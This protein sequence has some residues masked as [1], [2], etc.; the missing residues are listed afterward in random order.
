MQGRDAPDSD[1]SLSLSTRKAGPRDAVAT[2]A[3]IV[4]RIFG[5]CL[6]V[7]MP[8]LVMHNLYLPL[9]D[10]KQPLAEREKPACSVQLDLYTAGFV[11]GNG[12]GLH[13]ARQD[14]V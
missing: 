7:T 5:P 8:I 14:R 2:F 6:S 13:T 10:F 11:V 3:L 9:A 4:Q 12:K 1:A